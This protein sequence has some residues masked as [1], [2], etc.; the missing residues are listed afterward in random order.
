MTIT[1]PF[2]S[3]VNLAVVLQNATEKPNLWLEFEHALGSA[4]GHILFTALVFDATNGRMRRIHSNREDVS[5]LGGSKAVTE[6]PWVR[7]VLRE[8][9][10]YVGST[11]EDIKSVFSEHTQLAAIGCDSVL[12][13]PVRHEGVTVGTLNLLDKA[14]HYDAASH[15][16]ALV[17]AQFAAAPMAKILTDTPFDTSGDQPLEFV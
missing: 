7:R 1:E 9:S 6:S 8:G 2:T 12:N 10:I 17:F 14:G 5:P 15:A 4:Y 3:I 16:A 13:I 11:R